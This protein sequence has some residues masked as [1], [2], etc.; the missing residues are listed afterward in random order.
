ML[1]S[2]ING[3]RFVLLRKTCIRNVSLFCGGNWEITSCCVI[4]RGAKTMRVG[5]GVLRGGGEMALR[6]RS[7]VQCSL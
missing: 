6:P 3:G 5:M 7:S 2:K 4:T 1:G